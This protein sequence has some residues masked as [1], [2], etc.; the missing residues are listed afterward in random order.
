M[1][2]SRERTLKSNYSQAYIGQRVM[3]VKTS[4]LIDREL[5][6][7]FKRKVVSED[8][9][10]SLSEAVEQAIRD[11]LTDFLVYEGLSDLDAEEVTEVEPI[12]PK[13]KTDAAAVIKELRGYR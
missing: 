10:R 5:W 7:M 13:M 2:G 8:S 3:K 4:I 6:N 9:L 11:E 12:K 1:D